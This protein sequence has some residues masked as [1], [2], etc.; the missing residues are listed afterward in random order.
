MIYSKY[1]LPRLLDLM[2]SLDGF[3]KKR[4]QIFPKAKGKIL[5]VG[6]GSGLNLEHYNHSN[7][8]SVVGI[9]PAEPSIKIAKQ[10][11][12]MIFIFSEV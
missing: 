4:Q 1:I 8:E 2:C 5:E 3:S 6:I 7:V 10:K 9:D 11:I 12:N